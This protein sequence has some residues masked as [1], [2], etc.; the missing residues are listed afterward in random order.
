[1]PHSFGVVNYWIFVT[2][3]ENWKVTKEKNVLGYA[4]RYTTTLSRVHKGDK[5]LLYITGESAIDGEYIIDSKVYR[6]VTRIFHTPP[7][8]P[9]ETFPLRFKLRRVSAPMKPI[10]F[11]PLISNVSF[12][13][14]KKWWA[15][16]FHGNASLIIPEQDYKIIVSSF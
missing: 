3:P 1:M 4:E 9:T 12:I 11:K 6:D 8:K 10:A 16:T 14:N 13:K 15:K 7:T 5:C 2:S